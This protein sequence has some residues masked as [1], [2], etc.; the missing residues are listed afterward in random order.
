MRKTDHQLGMS[1]RIT[2]RDFLQDS[3]LLA[4]G[5]TLPVGS[6]LAGAESADVYYPPTKT[7]LR[8]SHPG[9]FESAHE[10]VRDGKVFGD[11]QALAET[12]DLVVVGGGI[13]GLAT[14]LYYQD[15]FGKDA[16]ILILENHDDFGG[17]AKRNEFHQG[18]EMRLALGGVHNL[19]Y[20]S[21]SPNA[22]AML[23]RLGIDIPGLLK[24][25]DFAYGFSGPG[26]FGT[27]FDEETF[28]ENVLV[29]G[30][31]IRWSDPQVM[32]GLIDEMPLSE[33]AR[34]QLTAF[35]SAE[36]DVLPESDWEAREAILRDM[37]Y[38]DFL[39]EYGGLGDECIRLF[40]NI[41]HGAEGFSAVNLSVMEALEAGLPGWNLLGESVEH[42]GYEYHMA[43]F[44][45]GNASVTRLMVQQLIPEVAPGANADNIAVAD[46]DY[47]QLDRAGSPVRLRLN[48]TV[49]KA[50]NR[51]GAAQIQYINGGQLFEVEARHGVLACYHSIIPHLSPELPETQKEALSYQ[52]KSPLLLTNVLLKDA[53]AVRK[54]GITGAHCPGRM[55]ANMYVWQGN[56][57][58][59]YDQGGWDNEDGPVNLVFWGSIEEPPGDLTLKQ[60]LRASR[61]KMLQLEFEDYEREVRT[62]LDGMLGPYGLDVSEDIL[63][64][65][66]N[67]WP[68]GY[69]YWYTDLWDPDFE[70]G[71]WPHEIAR[72]PFGNI[73][74]ANADASSEAYT[75]MAIDEAY[76]AVN[77][78]PG[79]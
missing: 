54:A 78:L 41:T 35:Y 25:T 59:G 23:D 33:T 15:R 68:H 11:P 53:A 55:H 77:E 14:A 47:A 8:G 58:G 1:R 48:S 5:L 50:A 18:G 37:S 2:R 30:A 24:Q 4:L 46:F 17:H 29:P 73:A 71:Q 51:D 61:A 20:E 79:A 12:Y 38:F 16:R 64:I 70:E 39:R 76:R 27:F 19:E 28:G 67:R 69:S 72:Q 21:F 52:V 40:N 75:H 22:N 36:S 3:S 74:I 57:A 34:A 66:V 6:V 13:S 10:F 56:T 26:R 31:G 43:M 42:G 7:G 45:D 32:L 44:P 65:T 63:A 49:V 9:S 60:R 62:V